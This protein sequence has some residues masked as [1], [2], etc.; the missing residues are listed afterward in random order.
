MDQYSGNDDFQENYGGGKN[1]K[2]VNPAA[3]HAINVLVAG[4]QSG[5][6]NPTMKWFSLEMPRGYKGSDS[7]K[8]WLKD[9]EDILYDIFFVSNFYLALRS[10]Y[11]EILVYGT[12][13]L[14]VF[15][16]G[17]D[18]LRFENYPI[19][20]Y[21]LDQDP[22]NQVNTFF[23]V[24][25]K[26]VFNI[27]REFCFTE[28]KLD[29]K[30]FSL[31]S[32]SVRQDY[33]QGRMSR[34]YQIME[35]ILPKDESMFSGGERLLET[36]LDGD[37]R[38]PFEFTR[39]VYER[40]RRDERP[41]DT[42]LQKDGFHSFPILVPRW[43][44]KSPD[45]YGRSPGMDVLPMVKQLQGMEHTKFKAL[46]KMVN[47]PLQAAGALGGRE[48]DVEDGGIN[49]VN[50]GMQGANSGISPIYQVN[51][52]LPHFVNSIQEIKSDVNMMLMVGIFDA[53]TQMDERRNVTAREITAVENEKF[54]QLGPVMTQLEHDLLK[55]L[56]NISV[57]RVLS[58]GLIR[59]PSFNVQEEKFIPKYVS[60]VA[61]ALMER[62][63]V[64]IIQ[65]KDQ[66]YETSV[67]ELNLGKTDTSGDYFNWKRFLEAL[68][69][70]KGISP[71][72]L[73]SD[74]EVDKIREQR[75]RLMQPPE[76][77]QDTLQEDPEG[78]QRAGQA[79]LEARNAIE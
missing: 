24:Q 39:V 75:K 17:E 12:S 79:L 19:G 50:P 78:L 13:A 67:Q 71:D 30:K 14:G 4:L 69:D 52:N 57:Q 38:R 64:N 53:I 36:Y 1:N 28:G 60:I 8:I 20:T 65:F 18:G 62:T 77:E 15:D 74:S 2:I 59:P 9:L 32:A 45:V 21:W 26:T 68:R 55:P 56:V 10:V 63:I 33:E 61:M 23:R 44:L 51:P 70:Q 43:Y 34:R 5:I 11:E 49:Q 31:L 58:R 54:T 7:A 37:Q 35:V 76:G 22:L 16:H 73:L 3:S 72:F 27:V 25:N 46:K 29:K 41:T 42:F 66:V 40:P 48:I 6:T 47:P